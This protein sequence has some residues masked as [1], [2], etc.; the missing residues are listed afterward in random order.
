MVACVVGAVAVVGMTPATSEA[1]ERSKPCRATKKAAIYRT[2]GYKGVCRAPKTRPQAPPEPVALGENGRAPQALVD[3]AGTAHIVWNQDGGDAGPDVLRYCRLKRAATSCSNPPA[4]SALVPQQPG[5]STHRRSTRT[6]GVRGSSRSGTTSSS[7]LTA[8]RTS[9][10]SRTGRAPTAPPTSGSR[11]TGATRSRAGDR[12]DAEP[13]GGAVVYETPGGPRIGLISDTRTGGT[14][15]QSISPGTYTSAQAN[16]GAGGPDRAYSG[17]LAAAG[18]LPIAAFADLSGNTFIRQLSN[19]GQPANPAAWSQT[20]TSGTDPR[21][22]AGPSGVFLATAPQS[23]DKLQV[24]KLDGIQPGGA[25]TIKSGAYGA[26]DFFEDPGGALRLAW[27]D[28][29]GNAPELLERSSETGRRFEAARVLARTSGGI[30][31]VDLGGTTDGGGFALYTAGGSSQGFGKILAAPFGDQAPTNLTGIGN[32]PGGGADPDTTTSATE[33]SYRAVQMLSTRG[34]FLSAPGKPGVKVTEGTLKLNGL[35]VVPDAGVKILLGTRTKSIDTTG[36]VTV[37]LR[38]GNSVIKLWHGELHIDLST[39]AAGEKLFSVDLSK[40]SPDI[41]G[42]PVS[43]DFD[44]ILH[45]HSVEIPVQLKLPGVFGGLTG[46]ATLRAD[47]EHGLSVDSVSFKVPKFVLGPLELSDI[48]VSWTNSTDTWTG[49]AGLKILGAGMSAKVTFVAGKFREGSVKISPV[50]FPGVG[51]GPDV[52]LNNVSGALHLGDDTTWIEAGALFGAQPLPPD[53]YLATVDGR[54]RA[55]ITPKFALD[56]TGLGTIASIPTSEAHAH[57]DIDG[58]FSA[59]ASVKFD[60][61]AVSGSGKFDG[62]FDTS[63]GTFGGKIDS[64]ITIGTS[65]I[66]VD[67]GVLALIS[68]DMISGCVKPLGGFAYYFKSRNVDVSVGS[69]PGEPPVPAWIAKELA[70]QQRQQQGGPP[71]ARA[72]DAGPPN[73]TLP[74]GLPTASVQVTGFNGAPAAVLTSPA[75]ARVQAVPITAADAATAPAV[76]STAGKTTSIGLRKPQGGSWKVEESTPGAVAEVDVAKELTKPTVSAKVSGH[77]R[78]RVLTYKATTRKG[79]VVRFFERIG[80]GTREIGAVK[81]G[82][83][84]LR[85]QAGDGPAGTRKIVAQAEQG[86]MPVLQKAVASYRAPGPIVPAR[87]R[88]LRLHRSGS[89]LVARWKRASGTQQYVVRLAGERRTHAAAAGPGPERPARRGRAE[90]DRE[91]EGHRP[92]RQGPPGQGGEGQARQGTP[93]APVDPGGCIFVPWRST[94][95]CAGPSPGRSRWPRSPLPPRRAPQMSRCPPTARPPTWTPASAAGRSAA[96]RATR[97]GCRRS[98]T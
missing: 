21:L 33:I 60:L 53:A 48:E 89:S 43:G 50:P 14:F 92:Q 68:N 10:R 79:L 31:D 82:R 72:A 81:N 22:A 75:G 36:G 52:F 98:A 20:Q 9:S 86:G 32:L 54:L 24:R 62:F 16:L 88:G 93:Q 97:S 17:S 65:P 56:F 58:Y 44:V 27:V 85:F 1:R 12:G 29:D 45:E 77:G 30:D 61:E 46:G 76:Y 13:S 5:S 63:K 95:S 8:T 69:C 55:T 6:S 51:L 34:A 71:S 57:A 80:R 7:S 67:I 39:G 73:F 42:F 74:A 59:S 11:T 47:N 26:R 96:G 19:A 28:R 64:T 70:D 25:T 66:D 91:G 40:F 2:P 15:F 83:G 78:K 3:A 49:G 41:K 38:A 87:V 37:Q 35:E 84:K 23:R 94:A 18:G 90:R 4:T